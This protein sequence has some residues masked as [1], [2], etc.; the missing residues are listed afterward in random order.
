LIEPRVLGVRNTDGY[1]DVQVWNGSGTYHE[2]VPQVSWFDDS[3]DVVCTGVRCDVSAIDLPKRLRYTD[4]NGLDHEAEFVLESSSFTLQPTWHSLPD[5]VSLTLE[6]RLETNTVLATPSLATEAMRVTMDLEGEE[7][8]DTSKMRWMTV[9]G[10]G[11]FLELSALRSDFFRADI[12]LDRDE[13]VEN[14]PLNHEHATIF[15]LHVDGKGHNQWT[16]MDVWYV[17][18]SLLRHQNRLLPISEFPAEWMT[19]DPL[20]VTLVWDATEANWLL[21]EPSMVD[22]SPSLPACADDY[23]S[24]D[25]TLLELGICTIADLDGQRVV[26]ETQ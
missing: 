18:E 23:E 20:A 14:V 8:S 7:A 5:D 25:W 1:F 3:G 16:W 13:V 11:T 21:I 24:F 19:G 12:L 17:E 9:D 22:T 2:Q 26:L 15:G 6:S 10:A 4:P